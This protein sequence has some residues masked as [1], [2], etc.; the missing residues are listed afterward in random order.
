MGPSFQPGSGRGYYKP[1][2]GGLVLTFGILGLVCCMPMGIAAWVM[3]ASDLGE[4][5]K[6]QM[7]PS[8]QSTTQIGMILGIISV[9]LAVVWFGFTLLAGIFGS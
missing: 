9:V 4:I 3:G 1:H 8:G 7:D 5:R 6:G 2:R